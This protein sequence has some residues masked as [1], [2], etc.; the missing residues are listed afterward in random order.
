[1]FKF[2]PVSIV[3]L[4]LMTILIVLNFILQI[5]WWTYAIL[6][7]I[8]NCFIIWG[9]F[10]VH[11]Q[12][13]TASI[14][15]FET[16]RP[17]V[18]LTFDDGPDEEITPR[19]LDILNDH[20]VKATFFC[21][22]RK[23][24]LF[25]DIVKRIHEEGHGLGLH[26]FSHAYLYD[27]YPAKHVSRDLKLNQ[28]VI[29]QIVGFRPVIFRPPYGVT[30]PSIAKAINKANYHV[31]GWS[32]RSLDTVTKEKRKIVKRILS[33][34][35]SGSII[36]LHDHLD[37]TPEVLVNLLEQMK[38]SQFQFVDLIERLPPNNMDTLD[39]KES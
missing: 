9:S 38:E 27:F 39:E 23:A 32:V 2:K 3:F 11:S 4:F 25:P 37:K 29:E 22:G 14:N 15:S 30:N 31:I 26:S 17:E 10:S 19:I 24:A 33:K 6:F 7:L 1:M 21:I 28:D 18:A 13:Y 34:L 8:Y 12:F 36:L 5:P 35:K 20:D 16:N